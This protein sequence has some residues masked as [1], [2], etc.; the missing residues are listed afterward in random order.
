MAEGA[1]GER[2]PTKRQ[3]AF[4]AALL[5]PKVL[6]KTE[7]AKIAGYHHPGVMGTRNSRLLGVQT[8]LARL[9]R[10]QESKADKARKVARL[11]LDEIARR[12]E[13]GAELS[14]PSV[15]AFAKVAHDISET[16]S[17]QAPA[18]HA[19]DARAAKKAY[20]RRVA[21]FAARAAIRAFLQA[22]V[23]TLE[24]FLALPAYHNRGQLTVSNADNTFVTD[25]G[26]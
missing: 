12:V 5:D 3:L 1:P 11:A 9:Q 6:T 24:E 19:N 22:K 7:A 26:E 16:T 4:A 8:A 2:E 21:R 18:I 17:E 20:G 13:R 10:Q 14:D 15:A 23:A 25:N